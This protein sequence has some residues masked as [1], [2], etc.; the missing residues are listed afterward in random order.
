VPAATT[1]EARL[2]PTEQIQKLIAQLDDKEYAKRNAAV[3]ALARV[4]KLSL[5]A[6]QKALEGRS[7][8]ERWWLEAAMQEA[9]EA[10]KKTRQG[11]R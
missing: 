3:A 7:E 1:F 11:A 5:P 2:D 10:A 6:L 8:G 9:Q 4:P